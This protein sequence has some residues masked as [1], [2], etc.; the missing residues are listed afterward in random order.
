MMKA[1]GWFTV[2]ALVGVAVITRLSPPNEGSCCQR[3]NFGARDRIAGKFGPFSDLVSGTFD[4]LGLTP[5]LA[6]FLDALGV[7]K[8]V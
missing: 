1:V 3:V 7:P 4:L 2:G 8:D 6:Q 5:H